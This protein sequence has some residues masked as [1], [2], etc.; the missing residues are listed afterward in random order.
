VLGVGLEFLAYAALGVSLELRG[1]L[2]LVKR[3]CNGG[4]VELA[5]W[6][7]AGTGEVRSAERS[8]LLRCE[9]S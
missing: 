7:G 3:R 6:E 5:P 1:I 4:E 8:D 2:S 9:D